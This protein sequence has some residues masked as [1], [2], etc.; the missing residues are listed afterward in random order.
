MA[1]N[2]EGRPEWFKIW[3]RNRAVIMAECLTREGRGKILENA[4]RYF[5]GESLLDMEPVEQI[6]WA[7]IKQSI[8]ESFSDYEARVVTNTEN[9]SHGG[10]PKKKP[11]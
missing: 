6:A 7:V 5:D 3:R 11:N 2:K 1:K 4:F 9:G 10:R 8:D